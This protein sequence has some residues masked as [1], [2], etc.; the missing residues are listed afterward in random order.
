MVREDRAAASRNASG[1]GGAG[2]MLIKYIDNVS[3]SMT[4]KCG[5]GGTSSTCGNGGNGG[6]TSFYYGASATYTAAGGVGGYYCAAGNG[7]SGGGSGGAIP[8]NGDYNV[9]G[10]PGIHA[11][12]AG[13]TTPYVA[14][15]GG[16][17]ALGD[18][19]T[20]SLYYQGSSGYSGLG[21]GAG[22]GGALED[23]FSM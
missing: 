8:T 21:Y 3:V 18:G 1:G 13:A 9:P 10:N 7:S 20:N 6:A 22:G 23:Q 4:Y 16:S 15:Y 11:F 19:G 2:S 14:G 17:S 12:Q 5:A